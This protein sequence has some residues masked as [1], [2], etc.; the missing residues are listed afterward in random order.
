[1][2]ILLEDGQYGMVKRY[3]RE[4][5]KEGC[6]HLYQRIMTSHAIDDEVREAARAV[7]A[8]RIPELLAGAQRKHWWDED[9]HVFVTRAGL[10]RYEA[11]FQDLANV[12]IPANAKAIGAAA[13][14][15]DLSENAE[16][17]AALEER[18]QLVA[19]ADRMKK[20]LEKARPLEEAPI[21]A[22]LV[23]PGTRVE[24]RN[25][26]TS[27]AE[28]YTILGP[29][30]ADLDRGIIS[31]TAPLAKGLLGRRVGET[32]EVQLPG[33]ARSTYRITKIDV[34]I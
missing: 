31:Y 29:W 12:K 18:N 27:A 25:E 33:G 11:E 5:E 6:R 13:A 22:D 21:E 8:R 14:L 24:L 23:G 15:G 17:T 19:R 34:A 10:A 1:V 26:S 2:R 32:V 9:S 3:F 4:A 20:D 16:F 7:I 28:H 30:D